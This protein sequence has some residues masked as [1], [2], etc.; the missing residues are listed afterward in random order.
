MIAKVDKVRA[1]RDGE[2]ARLGALRF[3]VVRHVAALFTNALLE[4]VFRYVP[5]FP[6][7]A[8]L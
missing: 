6:L 1:S 4:Q 7:S 8:A 3:L 5:R 2:Q